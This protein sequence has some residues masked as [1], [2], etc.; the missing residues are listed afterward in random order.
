MIEAIP[1]WLFGW[2]GNILTLICVFFYWKKMYT[3]WV[4]SMA[5]LVPY[6]ALFVSSEM[7]SLAGLQAIFMAYGLHGLL[8]WYFENNEHKWATWWRHLTTPLSVAIFA[9]TVFLNWGVIDDP[10]VMVQMVITVFSVAAAW[11]QARRY[12]WNWLV[13]LPANFLGFF[14]YANAG[15]WGLMLLQIP[16]FLL[17]VQGYYEWKRDDE[18][19]A[20]LQ[21]VEA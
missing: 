19:V 11:G 15:F 17:S 14:Y 3:A 1:E 12:A 7:W 4:L 21:P 6:F 8:L 10:W 18:R 13:W 20:A 16:L 5:S 9:Y 2:T